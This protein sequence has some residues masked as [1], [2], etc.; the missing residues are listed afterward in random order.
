MT[1]IRKV[2]PDL[3]R[4]TTEAYCITYINNHIKTFDNFKGSYAQR[5]LDR[6]N[7]RNN[8]RTHPTY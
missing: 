8:T 6:R 5:V 4:D 3:A 7:A 2:V 1:E